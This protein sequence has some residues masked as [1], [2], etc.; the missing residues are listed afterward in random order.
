MA[1]KKESHPSFQGK[2]LTNHQ[3]T[4]LN[5]KSSHQPY[6]ERYQESR[7]QSM[8]MEGHSQNYGSKNGGQKPFHQK[9]VSQHMYLQNVK[10]NQ[11]NHPNNTDVSWNY[12][13]SSEN[14]EET[15]VFGELEDPINSKIF[16]RDLSEMDYYA[17]LFQG[18]QKD[19]GNN[20]HE[21]TRGVPSKKINERAP[22]QEKEKKFYYQDDGKRQKKPEGGPTH[23]RAKS[24]IRYNSERGNIQD[25]FKEKENVS[26]TNRTQK[27]YMEQSYLEDGSSKILKFLFY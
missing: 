25:A 6:S 12:L 4:L 14:F 18:K 10:N 27:N 23:H 21:H 19:F 1:N 9:S 13:N 3:D 26:F 24:A 8:Q 16:N 2:L 15:Q 11:N 5:K 7:Q 20:D 22:T 17:K